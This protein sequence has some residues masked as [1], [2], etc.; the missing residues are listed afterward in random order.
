MKWEYRIALL[1]DGQETLAYTIDP[2]SGAVCDL[3]LCDHAHVLPYSHQA[4]ETVRLITLRKAY[5]Q[6][7]LKYDVLE[8]KHLMSSY[9]PYGIALT[10]A[11]IEEMGGLQIIHEC[12]REIIIEPENLKPD[13][14]YTIYP[15]DLG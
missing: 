3:S 10:R 14:L 8:K 15:H 9:P 7:R 2:S 13:K 12:G 6:F 5:D 1:C 11:D 4:P